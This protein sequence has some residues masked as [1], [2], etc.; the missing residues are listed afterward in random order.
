MTRSLPKPGFWS[1]QDVIY[2]HIMSLD[3]P[4]KDSQTQT[5]DKAIDDRRQH[6]RVSGPFDGRRLGILDTPIRIYD[7]SI[8]GCFINSLH[9][10]S[11]DTTIVLEIDLP[12]EGSIK[13][14]GRTLYRK[15]DYGYAVR[16][17]EMSDETKRRLHRAIE[18]LITVNQFKC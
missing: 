17:T 12:Y 8:G 1:C 14:K 13:V 3:E 16:F 10:Q 18:R 2:S 5:S 9:D 15:P 4:A 7:L 11:R 6:A